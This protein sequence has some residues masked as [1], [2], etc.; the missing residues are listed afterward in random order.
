MRGLVSC[1]LMVLFA[2]GVVMP[3]FTVLWVWM[4]FAGA[5]LAVA[6]KQVP[7]MPHNDLWRHGGNSLRGQRPWSVSPPCAC[8][9]CQ[10][11]FTEFDIPLRLSY[12]S[13]S[14]SVAA[15]HLNVKLYDV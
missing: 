6:E 1:V 15:L 2:Y 7:S 4:S 11:H 5:Q 8:P 13:A 9:G 14:V 10:Y 3:W 12:F